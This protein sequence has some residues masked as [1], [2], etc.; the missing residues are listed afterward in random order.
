MADFQCKRCGATFSAMPSKKRPYCGQICAHAAQRGVSTN[1]THG[2]A[3]VNGK[4]R[5]T[6]EYRSWIGM[7]ERCCNQN[8]H[9]YPKYGGRGISICERWLHS[10]EN[11]LADMGP[12]PDGCSI[13]RED[14]NGNYE[15][16]N[17]KWATRLEQSRNRSI[18]YT[19]QQDAMIRDMV[20]SGVTFPQIARTLGKS[21][22][23]VSSRYY[24]IQKETP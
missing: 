5:R 20:A 22:G 24:R 4:P 10:F 8:F 19:P 21:S 23:A 2:H 11:F 15:P 6:R 17:C 13:E 3:F 9:A 14:N 12:R 7:K 18:S 1:K 16:S